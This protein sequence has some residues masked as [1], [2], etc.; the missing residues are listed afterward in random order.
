[1]TTDFDKEFP[2]ENNSEKSKA[3]QVPV[4][5]HPEI[6]GQLIQKKGPRKP[7][8]IIAGVILAAFGVAG[9]FSDWPVLYSG[10]MLASGIGLTLSYLLL[11][12]PILAYF[13]YDIEQLNNP[14]EEEDE[15]DAEEHGTV[16]RGHTDVPLD[17]DHERPYIWIWLEPP[18]RTD[19]NYQ[20]YQFVRPTFSIDGQERVSDREFEAATGR[21]VQYGVWNPDYHESE[22]LDSDPGFSPDGLDLE[23]DNPG[24][25]FKQY[26]VP[27]TQLPGSSTSVL[28][29]ILDAPNFC[30]RTNTHHAEAEL[31]IEDR[32]PDNEQT[33]V[34]A[35][36]PP[37]QAVNIAIAV[38]ARS[39]LVCIDRDGGIDC[40]GYVEWTYTNDVDIRITWVQ[41]GIEL[42]S[43]PRWVLSTE[44]TSCEFSYEFGDWNEC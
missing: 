30:N 7:A 13:H 8:L 31:I 28:T 36:A 29:G 22:I 21:T 17:D 5:Y 10:L 42:G 3:E 35:P 1:M 12:I 24:K 43:H 41:D 16:H 32:I 27:G 15:I 37:D 33:V 2:E 4:V 44:I 25:P 34:Q 9:F 20:W 40:I 11:P 6:N 23:A 18:L 14:P 19:C 38:E 26:H 39:Y